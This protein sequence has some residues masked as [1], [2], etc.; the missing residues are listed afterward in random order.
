MKE[1]KAKLKVKAKGLQPVESYQLLIGGE[2]RATALANG[3]G[4]TRFKI[5]SS[6]SSGLGFDPR[7]VAIEIRSTS[8]TVLEGVFATT[9]ESS[10]TKFDERA[11]LYGTALAPQAEGKTRYRIKKGT[12]SFECEVED[13]PDGTYDL[14]V[15]GVAQVS[16]AVSDGKGEIEIEDGLAF[17]PRGQTIDIA[18][19][20]DVYVTGVARAP[21]GGIDSCAETTQAQELGAGAGYPASSGDLEYETDDD[22][23]LGFEIEIED[24]PVGNYPVTINE[25]PR[26]DIVVVDTGDG[27]EGELEFGDDDAGPPLDFEPIGAEVVIRE[28]STI[29]WS[30]TFVG[31]STAPPGDACDGS[32]FEVTRSLIRT[33]VDPSVKGEARYRQDD[34]CDRDFQV[35]IEDGALGLHTVWVDGIQKGG[36]FEVTIIDEEAEGEIEFDSEPEGDEFLLDFDPGGKQIA[37]QNSSGQVILEYVFPV[38]P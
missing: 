36:T 37:V 13:L 6:R 31:G 26:G 15:G 3:R 21:A 29:L 25:I 27:I 19:G 18:Q 33:G 9:G 30:T 32:E 16:I 34:D 5:Q 4:S 24:V 35:E 7:G 22:C 1:R 20:L 17:D 28:G 38:V 23:E 12:A 2:V 8:G 14:L 10:D 11:D